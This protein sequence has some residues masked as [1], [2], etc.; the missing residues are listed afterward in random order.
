MQIGV[1]FHVIR[2]T[3]FACVVIA[4][5][6][7]EERGNLTPAEIASAPFGGRVP[8]K[9]IGGT[10]HRRGGDKPRHY[11]AIRWFSWLRDWQ[12][13]FTLSGGQILRYAQNDKRRRAQ[14]DKRGGAQRG[15]LPFLSQGGR[16]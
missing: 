7:T 2:G 1:L 5:P 15:T 4:S 8:R 10:C 16:A 12:G 14:N 3:L 11:I 9:D 13:K 6:S